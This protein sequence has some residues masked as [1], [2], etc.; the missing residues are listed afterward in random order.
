MTALPPSH[1]ARHGCQ[2]PHRPRDMHVVS[3]GLGRSALALSRG[4][5]AV[6]RGVHIFLPGMALCA[7][8]GVAQGCLLG[9]PVEVEPPRENR[10]PYVDR[11]GVLP[12]DEIVFAGNAAEIRLSLDRIYDP[13]GEQVLYYAWYSP[14]R[15]EL[16]SSNRL[17]RVSSASEAYGALFAQYEPVSYSVNP[18]VAALRGRQTET[19]WFYLTDRPWQRIG[20]AG[21]VA[22]E[23]AFLTS[24]VWVIDLSL[25]TCN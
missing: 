1:R 22:E 3:L 13:D 23:G 18:C 19:I 16:L 21:L 25:V 11:D 24:W 10:P 2:T 20:S 17:G 15:S 12:P 6:A 7:T 5:N 4:K 14:A 8:L 9:P